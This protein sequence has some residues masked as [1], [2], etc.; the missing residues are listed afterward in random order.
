MVCVSGCECV[1][2][3]GLWVV[4]VGFWVGVERVGEVGFGVAVVYGWLMGL[5]LQG[6]MRS[7]L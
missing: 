2:G 6:V 7:A 1:V 3:S 5:V 4:L